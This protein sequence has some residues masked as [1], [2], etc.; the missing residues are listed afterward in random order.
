MS[1]PSNGDISL[2]MPGFAC[3]YTPCPSIKRS[4]DQNL[5]MQPCMNG[6]NFLNAM[7]KITALARSKVTPLY[8]DDTLQ[9]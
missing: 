1:L 9:A 4:G 3:T 7:S 8:V 6:L 2:T 5:M